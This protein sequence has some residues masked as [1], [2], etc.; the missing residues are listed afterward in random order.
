MTTC[1]TESRIGANGARTSPTAQD[2]ISQASRAAAI[3]G[4]L[5][6]DQLTEHRPSS[7]P[8]PPSCDS[9]SLPAVPPPAPRPPCET[10]KSLPLP[11]RGR[12]SGNLSPRGGAVAQRLRGRP[13]LTSG[14]R[15][16]S[17]EVQLL[18]DVP[19]R[20]GSLPEASSEH[21][22]IPSPPGSPLP[23]RSG[24]RCPVGT[25]GGSPPNPP[26]S[27]PRCDPQQNLHPLRVRR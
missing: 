14:A 18:D 7:Q 23:P 24:G 2:P 5:P 15:V 16:G 10:A 4:R 13:A 6:P 25:E 12:R 21:A 8:Q 1:R 19:R 26:P 22:R 20:T 9:P 3:L 17:P 27:F 11:H